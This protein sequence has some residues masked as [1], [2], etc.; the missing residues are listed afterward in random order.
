MIEFGHGLGEIKQLLDYNLVDVRAMHEGIRNHP[1][2][3][4]QQKNYY[5]HDAL[6]LSG[7][8]PTLQKAA[9]GSILL[10]VVFVN[11]VTRDLVY[12]QPNASVYHKDNNKILYIT[13]KTIIS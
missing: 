9:K 10:P 13:I 11:A 3:T 12:V 6:N 7:N 1:N 4:L 8:S 2:L 5:L